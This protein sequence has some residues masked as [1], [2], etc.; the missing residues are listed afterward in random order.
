MARSHFQADSVGDGSD[1]F[2]SLFAQRLDVE[3][4][5]GEKGPMAPFSASSPPRR[6]V[7]LRALKLGDLLCAV[8][9]FRS[10]RLA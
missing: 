9:V 4:I 5:T 6:V 1:R 7:I 3:Y 2:P 10:M 8:P